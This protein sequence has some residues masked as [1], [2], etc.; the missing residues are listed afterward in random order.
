MVNFIA[1]QLC[2]ISCNN[3]HALLKYQQKSRV[4]LLFSCFVITPY[5]VRAIKMIVY[6]NNT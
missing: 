6:D 2:K 4:E 3:M 1:Y 5:T